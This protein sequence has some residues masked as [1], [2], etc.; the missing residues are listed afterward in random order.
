MIY[1]TYQLL[2]RGLL[3]PPF[4]FIFVLGG[5]M[6]LPVSIRTLIVDIAFPNFCFSGTQKFTGIY[7]KGM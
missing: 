2:Q 6:A 5:Y 1:N 4:R 7:G 3:V